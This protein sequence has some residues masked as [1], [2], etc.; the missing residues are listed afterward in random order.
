MT[1]PPAYYWSLCAVMLMVLAY[2]FR[3]N[4]YFFPFRKKRKTKMPPDEQPDKGPKS[5]MNLAPGTYRAKNLLNAAN[6]KGE[7][8]TRRLTAELIGV[9]TVLFIVQDF[10]YHRQGWPSCFRGEFN[11][12]IIEQL[13]PPYVSVSDT[14]PLGLPPWEGAPP[15]PLSEFP[16]LDDLFP[17]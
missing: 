5:F 14:T 8:P 10:S 17:D 11:L 9:G 2:Q 16:N 15:T 12:T 3:V 13:G 4:E 1:I 7:Y 6:Q